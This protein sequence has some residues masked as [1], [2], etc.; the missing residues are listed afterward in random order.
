MGQFQK[1]T[2]PLALKAALSGLVAVVQQEVEADDSQDPNKCGDNRQAVQ[3]L[4][5]HRGTGKVR[6]HATTE[7]AGQATTLTLVQEHRQAHQQ[8][9]DDQDD[10]KC[11]DQFLNL[12]SN[13]GS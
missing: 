12:V 2:A 8:A 3:V 5:R 13:R 9:R 4:L 11:E 6:L 7:Q 1:R 10:L